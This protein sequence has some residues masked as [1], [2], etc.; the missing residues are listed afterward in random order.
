MDLY[1]HMSRVQYNVLP[2]AVLFEI[3]ALFGRLQT[4]V[5]TNYVTLLYVNGPQPPM[6]RYFWTKIILGPCYSHTI[7]VY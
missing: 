5:D 6:C 3:N 4:A 7:D 1:T 2:R